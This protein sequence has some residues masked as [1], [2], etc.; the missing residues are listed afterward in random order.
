[1]CSILILSVNFAFSQKHTFSKEALES[2]PYFFSKQFQDKIFETSPIHK[3][4]GH[5]SKDDWAA[6]IDSAWGPGLSV[7]EKL[8]IFDIFTVAMDEHFACFQ[9][10][11]CDQPLIDWNAMAAN[12]RQEIEDTVSRGRFAAI[13][14][15]LCLAT[16][17][18]HTYADDNFVMNA[19]ALAPGLPMLVVGGWGNNTHFGAGLTPLPD[20]NLLVYD[21]VDDHVL[22][23]ESGDIVLGYDGLLWKN[24]YLEMIEAE[25]PIWGWWWGCSESAYVHSWL[26]SAGMNWH[27]FDT[28]DFIKYPTNDTLH[29]PTSMLEQQTEAFYCG[30]ML[31]IEGVEFPDLFNE[32]LFSY[33]IVEGTDIG[34]IYGWGWYWNAE[35]EFYEAIYDLMENY[36]T[37]GL[38]I[39]FR[40]NYGGNMFL[41][42]LGLELLFNTQDSTIG[43]VGRNNPEDHCSWYVSALPNGYIIPGDTASYYDKPIAVLTGPGA[44]S[45]GDQVALRMKFHPMAR[46][47]GKSTTAAFNAPT[48]INLPDP[49]WTGRYAVADAYLVTDP[50]NNLTHEEFQVDEYVWHTQVAVSQGRDAVV[51]AAIEW[52]NNS[53]TG[54]TD[55]SLTKPADQIILTISPNPITNSSKI[56]FK[57]PESSFVSLS[58]FDITGK[59]MET[60]VSAEFQKGDHQ[61][62]WNADGLETG[63]Y[64]IRLETANSRQVCKALITK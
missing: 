58:V 1:M 57:L 30:E 48:N 34:Y 5:Y 61:L 21:V 10:L 47:F 32:E 55:N 28:I 43:I 7:N 12:Y 50:S 39:D 36:E 27:L 11:E 41:S 17:E 6:A 37:T 25:L 29:L 24:L 64:F 51:E 62:Q 42:N 20:S 40:M 15:Q 2:S 23:L 13:M 44:I 38:I 59:K 16:K 3:K 45:S 8:A 52:I 46:I 18:A 53:T 31:P 60:I 22:G 56:K 63:I 26:M 33:G 19:F 49:D 35:S 4:P 54:I 9:N 14:H